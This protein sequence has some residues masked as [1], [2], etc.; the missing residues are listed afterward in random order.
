MTWKSSEWSKEG[1]FK[2]KNKH[3]AKSVSDKLRKSIKSYH[4]FWKSMFENKSIFT[5]KT[6]AIQLLKKIKREK[7]TK[8]LIVKKWKK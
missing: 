5:F 7:Q 8:N 3:V 6:E 1:F 4:L 2:K